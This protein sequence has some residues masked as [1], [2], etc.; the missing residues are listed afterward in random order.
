VSIVRP[1]LDGL[2]NAHKKERNHI[3]FN[4]K[5][6]FIKKVIPIGVIAVLFAFSLEG[7]PCDRD[8]KPYDPDQP[9]PYAVGTKSILLWDTSRPTTIIIDQV[10]PFTRPIEVQLFYPVDPSS[11]GEATPKAVYPWD[12]VYLNFPPFQMTSDQLEQQGIDPS[13]QDPPISRKGPFPLILFS[14]GYGMEPWSAGLHLGT[15]LASHGF[16]V[17]SISHYGDRVWSYEPQDNI[18]LVAMNRTIDVSYV[19]TKLLERNS[20][21]GD[22][23][24]GLMDSDKVAA[25]GFSI[26]AYTALSLAGGDDLVCDKPSEVLGVEAPA[27]TCVAAPV[28]PRIHAIVSI[29][30]L[31]DLLYFNELARIT[32]P[33]LI[34]GPEWDDIAGFDPTVASRHA[35]LHAATQGNPSYRVDIKGITSHQV[36]S[37]MCE[38]LPI[39]HAAGMYSEEIYPQVQENFCGTKLPTK[40]VHRIV[41]K[42]MIAFLKRHL[43]G[44][45]A[46]SHILTPEYALHN[47]DAVE[48]FVT[49]RRNRSSITED[50]PDDSTYFIHQKV[51]GHHYGHDRKHK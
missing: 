46:Y 24:Y 19:L 20:A 51:P 10:Y 35:R 15:R 4:K 38:T 39:L 48:F 31:P 26:G 13:Y 7:L 30:G 45:H 44:E 6:S 34:L 18:A 47:E 5:L 29:D 2:L 42:Y 32:V 16:V 14:Q 23:L 49:E 11:V 43:N 8:K 28:D 36:F 21:Q 40:E 17:A 22:A 50:W 9:G 3:V 41:T 1:L 25:S 27:N 33:T 12:Q 37:N